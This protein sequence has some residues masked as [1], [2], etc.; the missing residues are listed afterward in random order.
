MITKR[1]PGDVHIA[2]ENSHEKNEENGFVKW[3]R[4]KN[5]YLINFVSAWMK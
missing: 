1:N 4:I 3:N 5:Q 2:V